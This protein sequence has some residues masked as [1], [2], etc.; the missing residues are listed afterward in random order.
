MSCISACSRCSC[1][2]DA[3]TAA[4][5]RSELLARLADSG[6]RIYAVHFPFPRLGKIERRGEE[7]VW[8]PEAL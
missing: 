7:F 6:E 8:I 1:D 4:A 5:S 2:G 3:P